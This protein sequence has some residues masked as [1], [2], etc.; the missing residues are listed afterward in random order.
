MQQRVLDVLRLKQNTPAASNAVA[1]PSLLLQNADPDV[2]VD[3]ETFLNKVVPE[4]TVVLT[5]PGASQQQ[6]L[7]AHQLAHLD[8]APN[9]QLRQCV[10]CS[11]ATFRQH[12]GMYMMRRMRALFLGL[13]KLHWC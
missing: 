12:V 3:M 5:R 6:Q 9:K 13:I 4:V 8:V 2:R 10:L 7:H 11:L 1:V